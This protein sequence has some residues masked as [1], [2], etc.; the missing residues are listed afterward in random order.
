MTKKLLCTL[1]PASFRVD[2]IPR[3]AELGA[4][5]F[6]IN[7]SHT[8]AAD[9]AETIGFIRARSDVPICLDS[10]GAQI[11]TGS[12]VTDGFDLRENAIVRVPLRRV[13]G[14][15]TS[16]NLYPDDI[17]TALKVGDFVSIDFNAVLVQVT[18]VDAEGAVMRVI[19]G[20]RVGRNKAV[21]VERDIHLPPLTDKDRECIAI[22]KDLGI[23]NFA[24]SF[25]NSGADVEEM[26]A[27][28][29]PD[30]YVISKIESLSGIRNLADIANPGKYDLAQV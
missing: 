13:P 18:A 3:L 9:L 22:G 26:R 4:S 7:L 8:R 17:V 10:E 29:G 24:L 15:P 20:G 19:S 21:T 23:E 11:R 14:D 16:F 12:F 25:A 30:A 27:L 6:R 2:V 28:V 1:G 5:L